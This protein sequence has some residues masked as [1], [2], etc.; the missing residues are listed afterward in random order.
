MSASDVFSPEGP[1]TKRL[2]D[3]DGKSLATDIDKVGWG[4]DGRVGDDLGGGC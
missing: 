1:T 3:Q 2:R 4:E